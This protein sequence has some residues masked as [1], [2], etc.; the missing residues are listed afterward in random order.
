MTA[1]GVCLWA[2]F[3]SSVS[4]LHHPRVALPIYFLE[5]CATLTMSPHRGSDG[6]VPGGSSRESISPAGTRTWSRL[7]QSPLPCRTGVDCREGSGIFHKDYLS[8]PRPEVSGSPASLQ[9][10][11]KMTIHVFPPVYGSGGFRLGKQILNFITLDMPVS[12]AQ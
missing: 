1:E 3:F 4:S 11:A 6:T 8:L 5:H 7:W 10:C 9:Q 12:W 2:T